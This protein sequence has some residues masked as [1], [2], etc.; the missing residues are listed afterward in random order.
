MQVSNLLHAARCKYRTQKN[1][2]KCTIWAPSHN[3]SGYIFATKAH[4]DHRKKIVKQQYLLHMS[5]QYSERWPTN[6]WDRFTSVGHPTTF[7]WVLRVG[8]VTALHSSSGRQPNFVALSTGRQVHLAGRSLRSASA[9]ILVVFLLVNQISLEPQNGFA[10][11]SQGR[12]VWS[13][14]RKIFN[15]KVK[16]QRSI[17]TRDKNACV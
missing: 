16:G 3:L 13:L 17:V 10:P 14:A 7:R 8:S 11:S 15:V 12:H 6:G 5:S 4:I 1:R 2:Q 9:H